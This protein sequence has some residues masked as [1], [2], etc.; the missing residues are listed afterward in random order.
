MNG[1]NNAE[2]CC[3]NVQGTAG[4]L[5]QC[6]C[7]SPYAA[8][9]H[10]ESDREEDVVQLRGIVPS[11]YL[12]QLAQEIAMQ[13]ADVRNVNNQIRV[14]QEARSEDSGI[15]TMCFNAERRVGP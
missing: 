4:S 6:F 3:E 13:H 5:Q 15:L 2:K 7:E 1:S 14:H 8:L 9:R 11:Y 10:V 12:K